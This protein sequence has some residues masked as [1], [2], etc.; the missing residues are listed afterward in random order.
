MRASLAE[1]IETETPSAQQG[2]QNIQETIHILIFVRPSLLEQYEE[3][4]HCRIRFPSQSQYSQSQTKKVPYKS[5][6]HKKRIKRN[7]NLEK[8]WLQFGSM[9]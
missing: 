1:Q 7:R 3:D 9:L 6:P 4:R 5:H 8:R 2:P